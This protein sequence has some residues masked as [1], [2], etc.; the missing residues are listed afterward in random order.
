MTVLATPSTTL[1]S[2][3]RRTRPAAAPDG[4]PVPAAV[5]FAGWCRSSA[6][7]P[8]PRRATRAPI[9][10]SPHAPPSST[11]C[12]A[13][14][15]P[16]SCTDSSAAWHLGQLAQWEMGTYVI[17]LT[18]VMTFDPRRVDDSGRRGPGARRGGRD[19]RPRAV[20][21]DD[22]DRDGA[23]R[24]ERDT[25][26]GCRPCPGVAGR[27]L[28]RNDRRRRGCIWA[29][30]RD[31]RYRRRCH[32]TGGVGTLLGRVLDAPSGLGRARGSVCCPG[33]RRSDPVALASRGDLVRHQRRSRP[34]HPQQRGAR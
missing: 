33:G 29:G 27:G 8:S 26:F 30:R 9:P 12:G 7:S 21:A 10:T 20:D 24:N 32:D 11:A 17:L 5:G 18:A 14:T 6:S 13:M 4:S 31:D 1:G 16:K 15:P 25:R 34:V 2:D 19:R 28:H 22:N 23:H 3:S